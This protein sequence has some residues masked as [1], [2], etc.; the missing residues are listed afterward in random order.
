[1]WVGFMRDKK[2]YECAPGFFVDISLKGST[3]GMGFYYTTPRLM[4]T[5]RRMIDENPAAWTKA[6][7]QAQAAGFVLAGDRYARPKKEGLPP[8]LDAVYNRKTITM[9]RFEPDPAFFGTAALVD[10][11]KEAFAALVP[12]YRL[13]IA[14]VERDIEQAGDAATA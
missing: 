3:Y 11:L 6:L 4:Q 2:A 5:V 1:M 12:L 13:L 7:K 9:D 10:V 14:A 8:L